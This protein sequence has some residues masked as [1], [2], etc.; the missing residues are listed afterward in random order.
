MPRLLVLSFGLLVIG[1]LSL[2][3]WFLTTSAPRGG[4][5]ENRTNQSE[6][7]IVLTDTG[8]E[9]DRVRISKGTRVLFSSERPNQFWP[10][11][12]AHPAHDIYA[13]FDPKRPLRPGE[14]WSFVFE[15]SGDWGFHDH[16]RSYFSGVIYVEE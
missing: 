13:E 9:P 16:I 10:A 7:A 3:M 11:S 4:E 8:F 14:S 15:K 5:I 12:N 6:V 1:A 2:G